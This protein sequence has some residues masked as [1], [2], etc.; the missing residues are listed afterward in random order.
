M[1]LR[2]Y[3]NSNTN[4]FTFINHSFIQLEWHNPKWA[5]TPPAY[6]F[7]RFPWVWCGLFSL[8]RRFLCALLAVKAHNRLY[9]EQNPI[10]L[11]KKN[12]AKFMTR[13]S[14][15][16]YFA[17]WL[18][19]TFGEI[20]PALFWMNPNNNSI[21]RSLINHNLMTTIGKVLAKTKIISHCPFFLERIEEVLRGRTSIDQVM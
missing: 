18:E 7:W 2:S 19:N 12:N 14:A 5:N 16:R 11:R 1:E 20:R 9:L 8:M 4:T 21:A 3:S 15:N 10:R 6:R 17:N 13:R